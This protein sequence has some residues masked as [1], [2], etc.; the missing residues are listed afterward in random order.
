MF[1]ATAFASG[2][3]GGCRGA[4]ADFSERMRLRKLLDE[5]Q[6]RLCESTDL[7]SKNA[8][9]LEEKNRA[10]AASEQRFRDVIACA[11]NPTL[12]FTKDG[13]IVEV[14]AALSDL[15]GYSRDEL[16][17][18]DAPSLIA[19]GE[20]PFG[21]E[22]LLRI[23]AGELRTFR[24]VKRCLHKDGRRIP[25]QVETWAARTASGEVEYFIAQGQDISGRLASVTCGVTDQTE[26]L[27]ALQEA[28]VQAEIAQAQAEAAKAQAEA[29]NRAKSEFLAK[30]S[31][32]IRTPLNAIM[33]M[34]ELLGRS[35]RDEE[36]AGYVRTLDSSARSM[37]VLL[38]D[39]LDL[40]KIEA[41]QLELNE[42]PFSLAEV[43]GSVADTFA[44][45]AKRKGLVL[46]VEPF[47]D[48]LPAML[49]DAIRLSQVLTNL[50]GNAL[51]FTVEGEVAVSVEALDRSAESVRIRVSVRDTGI[52][53]APEHIGKL[54]EPFVQAERTTYSNFGGTGLGLAI[55][56]Q[57][58][59]LMGGDIGVESQPGKGSAFWFV[60]LFKAAAS[61]AAKGAGAADGH[62]GK[63]LDGVRVLVVDDTE[64]NREVAVKLLSLE[65]A[66]CETAG[67]GRAAVELLRAS[68]RGFD[69]VLM[70]VQMPEMD[71]LEATQAI[72]HDL[73]L[74]GL[75]VIALTAGAMASQR[76]LAL[77]SGMNG[78]VAKPF[79]LEELVAALSPWIRREAADER[80]CAC[81]ATDQPDQ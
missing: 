4:A 74:D 16:L 14:N 11:P 66:I 71:G 52:G 59:G 75:P 58:V 8:L 41:G 62:R 45:L 69:C 54:F 37:L 70:D 49:G 36:R 43:V 38:T 31:H 12:L 1:G 67:N 79:R 18:M 28:K 44:V 3:F 10:L 29:A 23:A 20:K 73:E 32:E 72:R 25:V 5:E 61:P 78:F 68:P 13:G 15:L 50:V 27:R 33:G 60:V 55:S 77:A 80:L 2:R 65:G 6:R 42:I 57:L 34:I 48:G 21:L 22:N 81:T 47:P 39:L 19:P 7:L 9:L 76:E 35:A 46:R 17:S 51:K 24:L 30:I 64:T 56:K 26:T 40:S 63:R 53:V